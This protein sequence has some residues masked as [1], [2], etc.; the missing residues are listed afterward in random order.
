MLHPEGPEWQAI[1][2]GGLC[3][4]SFEI[5]L[6]RHKKIAGPSRECLTDATMIGSKFPVAAGSWTAPEMK[7]DAKLER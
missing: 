3:S 7:R 2:G 1:P 4:R 6:K 5:T